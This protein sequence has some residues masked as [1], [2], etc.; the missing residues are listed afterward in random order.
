MSKLHTAYM[1][2]ITVG[3]N[4]RNGPQYRIVRYTAK[5]HTKDGHAYWAKVGPVSAEFFIFEDS[6]IHAAKQ[7]AKRLGCK[8]LTCVR[9][10]DWVKPEENPIVVSYKPRR[11]TLRQALTRLGRTP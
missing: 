6:A 8:Y 9:Q 11:G 1:D 10:N 4:T 3:L 5:T 2:C 7:E